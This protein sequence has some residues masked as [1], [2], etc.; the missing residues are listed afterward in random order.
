[1][2]AAYIETC[3][4]DDPG[5]AVSVGERPEP[6]PGDDW[7]IVE[8]RAASLNHHDVF[9]ARGGVLLPEWLP[10]IIGM[11]AAGV[12]SQGEAVVVHNLIQSGDWVGDPLLDPGITGLSEG[13]DGTFA[14]RV[15][16]PR[17]N[18]V[19]LPEGFSFEEAAC[20]PTAWLTAY[21]MLFVEADIRPGDKV[22]VQGA[23]GGLSTA[24]VAMGSAAGIR[25]WVTGRTAEKRS[26]ASALGAELTLEPGGRL[27]E[28]VDA[29]M[30]SVGAPTWE[31]SLKSLRKGGTVVVA[32]AT[33]GQMATLDLVRVFMR[34]ARIVGS[35]MG[36]REDLD[37][38]IAFLHQRGVRPQV[39]SV[40]PLERAADAMRL[41]AAGDIRGKIVLKPSASG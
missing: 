37:R 9:A 28:R 29:V 26:Y 33:G 40:L 24:L 1:M 6:T 16:V 14:E 32:G 8:V 18:L 2:L 15:A 20:L 38:M 5:A 4:A 11:D 13:Y 30:E 41:M 35:T 7:A 3:N 27:P 19:P 25:M 10:R 17:A 39:E 22:L 31:H 23:A 12:T 34:N 36:T 21:H